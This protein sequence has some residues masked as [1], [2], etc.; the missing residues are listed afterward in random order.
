MG[1]NEGSCSQQEEAISYL[2]MQ[3][4]LFP[5]SVAQNSWKS[6]SVSEGWR[7]FKD[8]AHRNKSITAN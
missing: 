4:L 7:R 3:D 5:I 6:R 1:G 8:A 2:L